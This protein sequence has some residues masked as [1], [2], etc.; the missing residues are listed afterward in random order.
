MSLHYIE[1]GLY[2][3]EQPP[4][5]GPRK[6]RKRTQKL[7]TFFRSSTSA[8]ESK[9]REKDLA[10]IAKNA[11]TILQANG[12]TAQTCVY[13]LAK[14]DIDG[15]M[16]ST[17]KSQFLKSLCQ[18]LDFE[19]AVSNTFP[20]FQIN[21]LY[22]VIDFLYFPYMPPPSTATTYGDYF[23]VLWKQTV[24]K[25]ALHHCAEDIV[26]VIDKPDFLPP[27]RS[28]VHKARAKRS[29]IELPD[30]AI[31]DTCN[32]SH[33][34]SYSSILARLKTFKEQ[35]IKYMTLKFLV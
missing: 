22:V 28:I 1:E 12:I 20:T 11:M 3:R 2:A 17:Q 14:A 16:R 6:R 32:V 15:N 31:S 7:A 19:Q 5:S 8:S 13:P 35:P 30:Q 9:K 23:A 4:L 27:P 24:G 29:S 18:C 25:Y 26:I 34:T 33:G 21:D 10:D